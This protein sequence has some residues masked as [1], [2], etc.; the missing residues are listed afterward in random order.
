VATAEEA[1]ERAS[2]LFVSVFHRPFHP[3]ETGD[4]PSGGIVQ[5]PRTA[6]SAESGR[7]RSV[8]SANADELGIG[9]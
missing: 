6:S 7:T 4:A 5:R 2:E 8:P 1:V 3:G 9:N